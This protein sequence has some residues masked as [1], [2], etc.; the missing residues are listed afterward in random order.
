MFLIPTLPQQTVTFFDHLLYLWTTWVLLYWPQLVR[1]HLLVSLPEKQ[2]DDMVQPFGHFRW[3]LKRQSTNYYTEYWFKDGTCSIKKQN[4][5]YLLE[6]R[7]RSVIPRF[8]FCIWS[9]IR[10]KIKMLLLVSV[11]TSMAFYK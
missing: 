9:D 2:Q 4:I 8:S 10:C 7:K 11:F 3:S 5:E 1:N 6:G